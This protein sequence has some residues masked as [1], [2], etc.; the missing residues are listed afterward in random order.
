MQDTQQLAGMLKGS[1][2]MRF[3]IGILRDQV[4]L[5]SNMALVCTC[6]PGEDNY[7]YTTPKAAGF[8]CMVLHSDLDHSKHYKLVN[9]FNE[10][11]DK[12]NSHHV[13]C[14]EFNGIESAAILQKCPS[15]QRGSCQGHY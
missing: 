13:L 11:Q 3:I 12:K 8:D 2:R 7:I 5:Q 6:F 10:H 15:F 14:D 9:N 4:L 1:P